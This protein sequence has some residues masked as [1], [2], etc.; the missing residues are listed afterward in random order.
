MARNMRDLSFATFNLYNLHL[1]G[2]PI[3]T[4][5][6]GLSEAHYQAKLDWIAR[7]LAQL[8][9]DV[10]GFQELWRIEA[11]AAAFALARE[12][13]GLA[14]YDLVARN[15]YPA[16]IQVALA[17][18]KGLLV[19]ESAQW[20]DQFPEACRFVDLRES[21]DARETINLTLERFSRP[22]L[23][24]RIQPRGRGPKPPEVVVYVAHLKSKGPSS[25]RSD[26]ANPVLTQHRAI[27]SSVAS[28]VRRIAEVGAL[29]A[30]LD[31]EMGDNDIPFVVLGDLNDGTEAISTELLSADPGYRLVAK[32]RAGNRSDRGLYSV[33]KLQQLR[34]FRHVYYT[35]VYQNKM[36][37]LDHILVSDAFYD[38]ATNRKW[39]FREMTGFNDH[40]CHDSGTARLQQGVSDHAVVR[41]EFDWNPMPS[42]A[43]D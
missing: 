6:G 29:R 28:H 34:S 3:Y 33:E 7:M 5:T 16:A 11:L 14:D 23:R 35:H 24:L 40:L 17:A 31:L 43:E 27:A 9:A 19:A 42:V 41:A 1:P 2:E 21:R 37:S 13:Y 30:M 8:D 36:E 4:N 32:S 20:I 25:L 39:S 12:R 18:K 10:I 38:A 26:S 22:P 15:R